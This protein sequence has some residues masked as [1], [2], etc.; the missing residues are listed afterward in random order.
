[1]RMPVLP[2]IFVTLRS[3]ACALALLLPAG[4]VMAQAAGAYPNHAIRLIVPFPSGGG[5]DLTARTVAQKMSESMGQPIVVDN[6]PGANGV[7]GTDLVAKAAPD[8]YTLLLVDRGALGIN[9]S[10]YAKLQ[11]D[12]L[13]DFAFI[14]IATEGPYVLVVNPAVPAKTLAELVALAKA[15]PGSLNYAS[16]GIGSMAQLN[17]EALNRRFGIDLAHVP[18]K[19]AGPAVAAVVAGEV[20]V[21]VASVPGVLGFIRDGRVRALAVGADR[22]LSLL[23]DVPTTAEAGGGADLL[24]PTFFALAAPAGTP[25]PIVAKLNAEL[26]RA[27]TAP[28]VAERF[29]AAGLVPTGGTPEAMAATVRED[30]ARFGALVKSI[31]IKPE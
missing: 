29:V 3:V 10:L 30:V 13:R 22:R 14:G 8:G 2:S 28:D 19:G 5:A 25:A 7:V 24:I 16:F 11:Y 15:K 31:G 20:G 18:Y 6:R 9:P 17:L 27:V 23:P 21:T 26:K 1:M 12:P 4:T